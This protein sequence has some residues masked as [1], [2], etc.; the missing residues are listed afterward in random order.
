[1]K[2]LLF[3]GVAVTI[4]WLIQALDFTLRAIVWL[5]SV[6]VALLRVGVA[7]LGLALMIAIDKQAYEDTI[8]EA[9]AAEEMEQQTTELELLSNA[10]KLKEH[11]LETGEWTDD[12][13]EALNAIGNALLND[14]DWDEDDIHRYLKEVVESGTGLSYERGEGDEYDD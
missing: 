13:S 4:F 9:R 10:T 8:E 5:E 11:A 6:L 1:M 12:H 2:K 3:N 14:C 7:K